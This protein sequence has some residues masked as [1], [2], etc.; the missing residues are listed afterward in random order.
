[1]SKNYTARTNGGK[2][3]AIFHNTSTYSS[4]SIISC[5]TYHY[6]ANSQA[7]FSSKFSSYCTGNLWRFIY[8]RQQICIN[9]Q[10]V[11]NLLRPAT[12]WYIEK[13]HTAGI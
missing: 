13:L 10:L 5:T 7:G 12:I 8:L 6:S 1:M 9:F 11:Q 4:S 3:P 2:G